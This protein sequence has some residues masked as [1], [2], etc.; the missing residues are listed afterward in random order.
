LLS[1]RIAESRFAPTAVR[2]A[3]GIG[4]ADSAM[5]TTRHIHA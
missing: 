5:T 2:N 1:V 4:F 3:A